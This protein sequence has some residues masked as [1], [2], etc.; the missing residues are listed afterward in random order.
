[1]SKNAELIEYYKNLLIMQYRDKTKARAHLGNILT[2]GMIYDIAIAVRDGFDIETAIGAQQDVLGR[3]LGVSR[4]ITGTTFTRDYYGYILYGDT[5]PFV[6]HRMLAYGE[7]TPDVQF[8]N[9]KE[10]TQSLYDLTDEEYR[11]IL[12]LAVVRNNSNASVK[13]IDEILNVLFGAE[14]YF[15]DRMN[16]TVVSYMVGEK[17]SRLFNI[18][19]S[20]NLLPNPAG[21]GTSLVVVPDINNIFAYSLYGGEKPAFATGYVLYG[22]IEIIGCFASYS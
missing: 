15:I 18:A 17:W 16:M 13:S 14:C 5:S 3:I 8:R 1:M 19:K 10:G 12:K 4:T 20:E 2:A 7:E 9:Y 22:A 21:V 6:F 11:I